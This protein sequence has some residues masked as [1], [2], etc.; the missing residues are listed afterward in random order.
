[1]KDPFSTLGLDDSASEEDVRSAYKA[2]AKKYH[3]DAN[4][5]PE[6]E[7][8]FKD[9]NWAKDEA[10]RIIRDRFSRPTVE[11]T[12]RYTFMNLNLSLRDVFM[13]R[14]IHVPVKNGYVQVDVPK[15]ARTGEVMN[16][17][18]D[19]GVWYHFLIHVDEHHSFDRPFE[20]ND[21]EAAISVPL[22]ETVIG[23]DWTIE[24]LDGS[25]L[26]FRI[27]P[28]T[29]HGTKIRFKGKGMPEKGTNYK[30]DL[31]VTINTIMPKELDEDSVR[32]LKLALKEDG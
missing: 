1:M 6:A 11:E 22:L 26:K 12:P 21:L 24:H 7:A 10:I 31:F 3:P 16:F 32:L 14:T 13:G 9:V 15:G 29:R 30:G 28:G 8:K 19:D 5:D 20:A 25:K 23:G 4:K 18:G 2:L 17:M 27:K